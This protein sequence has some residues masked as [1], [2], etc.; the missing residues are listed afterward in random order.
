MDFFT[1]ID[2]TTQVLTPNRRLAADLIERHAQMQ[3]SPAFQTPTILPYESWLQQS[4]QKLCEQDHVKQKTIPSALQEK[5]ILQKIIEEHTK[6]EPLLNLSATTKQVGDAIS[7]LRKWQIAPDNPDL[8]SHENSI[9][10]MA[11]A[12]ALADAYQDRNWL[13]SSQIPATLIEH[14]ALLTSETIYWIGFTELSPEQNALIKALRNAKVTCIILPT[15][16][17]LNSTPKKINQ[18]DRDSEMQLMANWAVKETEQNKSVACIV[19][20]LEQHR[21]D[22]DSVFYKTCGKNKVYNIS[23]GTPLIQ[24]PMIRAAFSILE[25]HRS[26]IPVETISRLLRSPFIGETELSER[27][28]FYNNLLECKQKS[29]RLNELQFHLSQQERCETLKVSIDAFAELKHHAP[30]T[31]TNAA[32]ALHFSYVL[33]TLGWP[34]ERVLDSTEFQLYARWEQALCEFS[35]F[36]FNETPI[37]LFEALAQLTAL[38]VDS[39]F[40]PQQ[41]TKADI[42]ILGMLEAAGIHFDSVWIMGLDDKTW[43]ATA[44]PNPYIPYQMQQALGMPHAD[45]KKELHFADALMK[46]LTDAN[47]TVITSYAKTQGDKLFKPSPLITSFEKVTML[48]P[49]ETTHHKPITLEKTENNQAG[50]IQNNETIR[51][52][53]SIIKLQANCPFHAFAQVRLRAKPTDTPTL[54]IGPMEKGNIIHL[55]LETFWTVIKTQEALIALEKEA[56][57]KTINDSID[58]AFTECLSPYF[59]NKNQA[60]LTIE[61]KRCQVILVDWLTI[62]KERPPFTIIAHEQSQKLNIS[63]LSLSL[64]IDRIDQ[65]E[66]GKRMII[67]YKTGTQKVTDW[68]GSRPTEPQLPLYCINSENVGAIAIGQVNKKEMLYK[69]VASNVDSKSKHYAFKTV[70]KYIA[71]FSEETWDEQLGAWKLHL[72]NLG[73]NFCE[74]VA[75]VDPIDSTACERC[76]LHSLCRI[77]EEVTA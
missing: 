72:N 20:N 56:L 76:H 18:P 38:A 77:H 26:E 66:N 22:I 35:Q 64:R 4:Y 59:R 75:T 57:L 53:T 63:G 43:P 49:E 73:D 47:G 19:P 48:A 30:K 10:L 40:Q 39:P 44:K 3:S 1:K 5:V 15:I 68:F 29:F 41:K 69:G 16:D 45:A 33:E 24:Y 51:G 62:E 9:N 36:D 52:G 6:D 11:W 46:Q 25:L 67:D 27:S 28:L 42:H 60:L 54:G 37:T 32:W 23:A 7:I 55:A 31:Q 13:S 14:A 74:G 61:R 21:H 12:D 71:K 17:T 70:D 65:L 2:H 8:T 58:T 34:G 50:L